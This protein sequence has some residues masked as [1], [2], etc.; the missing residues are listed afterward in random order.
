MSALSLG[1]QSLPPKTDSTEQTLAL[2]AGS[3]I[4]GRVEKYSAEDGY[5]ILRSVLPPA[6][7]QMA[8][9]LRG[10]TQV[11][12]VVFSDHSQFP[13]AAADIIYGTPQAGDLVVY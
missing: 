11:A 1:C 6:P 5:V 4:A 3:R 8:A 7:G 12:R 10:Q 2:E 9:V 13:Y